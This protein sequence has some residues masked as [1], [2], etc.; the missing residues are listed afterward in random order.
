MDSSRNHT[1][2]REHSGGRMPAVRAGDVKHPGPA[3]DAAHCSC[4][5]VLMLGNSHLNLSTKCALFLPHIEI[6]MATGFQEKLDVARTKSQ[7]SATYSCDKSF[8]KFQRSRNLSPQKSFSKIDAQGRSIL[9]V[10]QLSVHPPRSAEGTWEDER[11]PEA[12][13]VRDTGLGSL[14]PF[15]YCDVTSLCVKFY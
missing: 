12:A 5:A 4:T 7:K 6:F 13:A 1:S 3:R 15:Y 14:F 11:C 9:F 2:W 8:K 10:L